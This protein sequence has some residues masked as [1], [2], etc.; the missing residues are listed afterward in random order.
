[1]SQSPARALPSTDFSVS[2]VEHDLGLREGM[3]SELQGRGFNVHA[4]ADALGFYRFL[5]TRPRTVSILDVEMP[6]EGGLSIARH[7]RS[8][9][10]QMGVILLTASPLR[11]VRLEGLAAGADACL[12]KPVDTDELVLLLNRQ[13]SRQLASPGEAV[14]RFRRASD[15]DAPWRLQV[16]TAMLHAPAG[17]GVRLTM[18]EVQVLQALTTKVGETCSPV[19]LCR[20]LGLTSDEWS[21]HRVEV[22]V[23]RLRQKVKREIG[24][25]LPLRTVRGHGYLWTEG[26]V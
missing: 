15:P 20:A 26:V 5:T 14:A 17:E 10:A 25:D 11:A 4:F 7:L 16:S 13:M 19:A 9:D 3:A 18:S 24:L 8:L 1:M 23:S 6:N 22:I 12:T 21:S 2:L